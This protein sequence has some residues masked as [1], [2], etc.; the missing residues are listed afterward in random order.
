M[1]RIVFD[2]GINR[3]AD[4]KLCGDV[5]FAAA[6]ERARVDHARS[7]RRRADDH[8]HAAVQHGGRGSWRARRA[9]PASRHCAVRRRV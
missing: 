3:G 2:V 1:A 7:G 4:G 5:E 8:R 6:A 9:R